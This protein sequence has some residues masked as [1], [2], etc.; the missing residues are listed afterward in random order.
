MRRDT[1]V[2]DSGPNI[3]VSNIDPIPVIS[4][5]HRSNSSGIYPDANILVSNAPIVGAYRPSAIDTPSN[6]P[7]PHPVGQSSQN[8]YSSHTDP[9]DS[10]QPVS[11]LPS[12]RPTSTADDAILGLSSDSALA[13]EEARFLRRLYTR[14]APAEEIAE[15]L[16]AMREREEANSG[17]GG[18]VRPPAYDASG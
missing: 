5:N 6:H 4:P 7:L 1:T 17:I 3:L 14:N 16:Q 13:A 10:P 8:L 15:L 18:E 9:S 11:T 12:V 2:L